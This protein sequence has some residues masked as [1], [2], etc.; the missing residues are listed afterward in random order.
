MPAQRRRSTR[1]P[2]EDERAS[3]KAALAAV[4][5]KNDGNSDVVQNTASTT[6]NKKHNIDIHE[7]YK[8]CV[9]DDDKSRRLWNIQKWEEQGA[10]E[11]I[12]WP[13][14]KH[15]LDSKEYFHACYLL[16]LFVSHH[17]VEGAFAEGSSFFD[18]THI[19]N[20]ND[21]DDNVAAINKILTTLL[22]KTEQTDFDLQTRIV[23]FLDVALCRSGNREDPLLKGILSHV[24]GINLWH[25]M[26]DRLREFELKKSAGLRRK[27]ASS[28]KDKMWIVTN[29]KMMLDLLE[30]NTEF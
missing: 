28:T 18:G 17:F 3:K 16:V 5:E 27:F 15:N 13:F 4:P 14:L 22:Y 21:D 2:A 20:T 11:E 12:V 7:L 8:I 30:G 26:P 6:R 19:N 29:V 24:S 9:L 25:W 10:I 1:D 23:H